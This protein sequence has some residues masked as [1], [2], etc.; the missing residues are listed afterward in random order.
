MNPADPRI[1]ECLDSWRTAKKVGIVW[2]IEDNAVVMLLDVGDEFAQQFDSAATA[3]NLTAED[4]VQLAFGYIRTG[5]LVANATS[6]M[7]TT[8]PDLGGATAYLAMTESVDKEA[9]ILIEQIDELTGLC[10]RNVFER[11]AQQC[12]PV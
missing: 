4:F 8:Y 9:K 3:A 10:R 12:D 6:D 1:R 5:L 11:L 7:E 2:N